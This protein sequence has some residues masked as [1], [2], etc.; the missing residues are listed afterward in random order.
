MNDDIHQPRVW[1][2]VWHFLAFGFGS[3]LARKA[4]GTW[5]TLAGMPFV[6]LLQNISLPL[7]L[8]VITLAT[9]FGI[10]LC[11][12]VADDLGVHDHGGIVWDEIVGIWITLVLL[13]AHWGWWLAGFVAFRFFD[14]LKPWPIRVLDRRLGGGL[15]IMLDDVLAGVFAALV[16]LAGQA[17]S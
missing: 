3:G 17:L 7:A 8:A 4:P 1:R 6:P 5:G 14:I 10:W 15:G 9:L 12:K 11:G 13:P 16:L 2:N